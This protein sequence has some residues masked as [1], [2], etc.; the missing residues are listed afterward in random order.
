M[1]LNHLFTDK[2]QSMQAYPVASGGGM[3]K[4][5]AM[6]SPYTLPEEMRQ[7]LGTV[8]SMININ[9][10]PNPNSSSLIALLRKQFNLPQGFDVMLGNGSDELIQL[11]L[12]ATMRPN[13]TVLSPAPSFV[14]YEQ[15]AEVCGMRYVGVDLNADFSLDEAAFLAAL[16]RE[17]PAV[18]FLA[19]PNNPTGMLLNKDFV[20]TVCEQAAGLVVI[21]EAYTAYADDNALDLLTQYDNVI[22]IRTL[23][24]IGLAGIRL[25][26]MVGRPELLEQINKVRMPYNINLLTKGAA[27]F[28]LEQMPYLNEQVE[29]ILKEKVALYD[30]LAARSDV[31]VYP[32]QTN[33]LLLRCADSTEVFTK[34]RD[35]HRILVK[36][37][38]G[39]HPVLDNVLR[40]TVGKAEEN[41]KLRE[42]LVAIL[43]V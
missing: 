6:E 25:G 39:V 35:E 7:A 34:L 31:T 38:H 20:K 8:L 40:I 19:Y 3:I 5:D 2:V 28:M 18:T 37:L 16:Q 24:K 26:Y 11:V 27:R 43:A 1:N 22:V 10:Y 23:S 32:S 21:D 17:Q 42:A 12:L 4:L 29:K 30:W 13:S 33:F 36:N 9:R 14:L 41:A 15:Y